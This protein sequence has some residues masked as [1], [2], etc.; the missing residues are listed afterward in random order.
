MAARFWVA[1]GTGLWSSTTNWAATS[2]GSSGASVPGLGDTATFDASSGA[3]TATVDSNIT[4]QTLTT[5]GFT[6]TLAF[7]TNTISL[8]ST[9]TVFT[10]ATTYTVTGTPVINVTSSGST[11][12][13]VT[14]GAVTQAN[15]IS[16]NFTAGTYTLTFLATASH[17]ARSVNFTGFAGTWA[18]RT[19]AAT[20]YGD[21]TISSGMTFA[22]SSGVLTFGA[23]S[24]TKFIT[25]N[26]VTI[27][28]PI[29][30][31]GVGGTFQLVDALTLSSTRTFTLTNGTFDLSGKTLTT[32]FFSSNTTT[33]RTLAFGI[34]NITC[35]GAGGTLFDYGSTGITVSGT[36]LVNISYS[37]STAVTVQ[38]SL[39]N[40][41]NSIS[42][43]ITAGTY[44]LSLF[45][46]Q[47]SV[48]DLNFTGFSGSLG[49]IAS[50]NS[51]IYGSLTLSSTMT[52][53]A[54]NG[55]LRFNSTGTNNTITTAGVA[56][57]IP[58]IFNGV[59]GV[60]KLQDAM[61]ITG[62]NLLNHFNGTIDLN[63]KTLTLPPV[64]NSYFTS[65]GTKTLAFTGGTLIAVF[66]FNNA[67]PTGYTVTDTVGT[68]KISVQKTTAFAFAGGG[69]T[70]PITISNDGVGALTISG[71][72]TI[73]TVTTTSGNV[74]LT[75]SNTI[76]TISNS[77]IPVTFT[78]TAGTTQT[79]TDWLVNGTSGNLVTIQSATAASHTLSKPS[80]TVSSNYLSISRSTA[81]GGATWYAGANS[82]NGGNN[83][84]W[85]FSNAP[86][87]GGA[88]FAVF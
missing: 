78:F 77:V 60:W 20:I 5:T 29:T 71:A 21:L 57:P 52:L 80:G 8:N 75:G 40:E 23:T 43:N 65:A 88:F 31:N 3:G 51:I 42:F 48:K 81:T 55:N 25:T 56:L 54:T 44:A 86:A 87:S 61:T 59:G 11:A 58:L 18:A 33:T 27:D 63:G 1:G 79:V 45:T 13:T 70:F 16:F 14:T 73:K 50:N 68:G 12:I 35:L 19:N 46:A 24:G 72:N 17:S 6:G 10:G 84:G 37:G 41:A 67:N 15:S 66:D 4:I 38:P 2:G 49:S 36:P 85:I 22:A 74:A 76:T 34:G 83:S 82:T 26:G 39:P 62:A 47:R 69:S 28:E 30:I 53:A 32:G 9:G 64:A 7:G